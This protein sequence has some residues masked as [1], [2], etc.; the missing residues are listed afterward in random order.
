MCARL[1]DDRTAQSLQFCAAQLSGK[2]LTA[3]EKRNFDRYAHL[4]GEPMFRIDSRLAQTRDAFGFIRRKTFR[5][6]MRHDHVID[7]IA[8]EP[9]VSIRR[10]DFKHAVVQFENRNVERAATQVE[11]GDLRMAFQLVESVSE[12]RGGRLVHDA[13]DGESSQL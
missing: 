4:N 8:A 2:I 3:S 12:R 7:V 10:E 5:A 9:R 6:E 11:D 1:L 13:L